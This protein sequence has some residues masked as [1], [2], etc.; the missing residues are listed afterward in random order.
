[1]NAPGV[2]TLIFLNNRKEVAMRKLSTP[3]VNR[4]VGTGWNDQQR[5]HGSQQLKTAI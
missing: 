4:A 3:D 5:S 1:M 2:H